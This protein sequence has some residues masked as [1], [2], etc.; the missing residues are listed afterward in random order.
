MLKNILLVFLGGGLGSV[1]RF[2]C[3]TLFMR[4]A[5]A[6]PYSGAT[7]FVNFAGSLLLGLV[8]TLFVKQDDPYRLLLAVGF[9]G[10]FT[11]FSTFS[12]ESVQYLQNG[13]VLSFVLYSGLS[14]LLG[15][16]GFAGGVFI[17]KYYSV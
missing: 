12:G 10:G 2:Y 11:T 16:A 8:L 17:A 4:Y 6:M 15:L 5:P 13:N 14:L 3:G 1:L 9:C 7:L